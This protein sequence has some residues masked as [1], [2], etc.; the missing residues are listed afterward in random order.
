MGVRQEYIAKHHAHTFTP[1]V[2]QPNHL[3]ACFGGSRRK[4][5]NLKETHSDTVIT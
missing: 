1:G 2:N 5:E 3:R 4:L